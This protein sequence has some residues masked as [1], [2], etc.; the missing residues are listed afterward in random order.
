VRLAVEKP[1]YNSLFHPPSTSCAWITPFSRRLFD[2]APVR[3][4]YIDGLPATF[5]QTDTPF[6]RRA[7][8]NS[9]S[10]DDS[11]KA[12]VFAPPGMVF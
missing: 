7:A 12:L 3:G 8:A 6:V 11:A 5:L 2:A 10:N 9:R 4:H 1:A